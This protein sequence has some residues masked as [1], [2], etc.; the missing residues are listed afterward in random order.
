[1]S[2]RVVP[3]ERSARVPSTPNIE[4]ARELLEPVVTVRPPRV[5]SRERVVSELRAIVEPRGVWGLITRTPPLY[6]LP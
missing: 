5:A 3:R 6:P 2:E 4:L 1:M